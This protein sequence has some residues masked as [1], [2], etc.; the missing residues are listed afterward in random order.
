M[1]FLRFYFAFHLGSDARLLSGDGYCQ[2]CGKL[3]NATPDDYSRA[4]SRCLASPWLMAAR[5]LPGRGQKRYHFNMFLSNMTP[6]SSGKGRHM[7][8]KR[9]CSRRGQIK[10]RISGT[11]HFDSHHHF[12]L[13]PVPDHKHWFPAYPKAEKQGEEGAES[14]QHTNPNKSLYRNH[15]E[16]CCW[17]RCSTQGLHLSSVVKGCSGDGTRVLP[18]CQGP[19]MHGGNGPA[20][21]SGWP[22]GPQ[23]L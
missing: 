1:L 5:W 8:Y 14:L 12:F 19:A 16:N 23:S 22:E 11:L 3:C 9:W 13:S 18:A 7:V 6:W 15:S 20:T 4:C 17:G 2:T 10:Y 21:G